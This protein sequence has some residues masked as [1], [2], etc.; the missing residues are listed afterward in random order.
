MFGTKHCTLPKEHH[1]HS[2]AECWQQ[3]TSP[4]CRYQQ[5]TF[6]TYLYK[7]QVIHRKIESTETNAMNS[8]GPKELW[9]GQHFQRTKDFRGTKED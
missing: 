3:T 7:K 4:K 5:F 9:K 8:T 6:Y 1:I 2:E